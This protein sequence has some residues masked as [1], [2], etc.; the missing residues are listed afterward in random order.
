MIIVSSDAVIHNEEESNE[1]TRF[2]I[3]AGK[4]FEASAEC[5]KYS[6]NTGSSTLPISPADYDLIGI[7]KRICELNKQFM[8]EHDLTDDEIK[9]LVKLKEDAV[10]AYYE[11]MFD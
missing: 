6:V 9:E 2:N 7:R 11:R 1:S 8:E 10:S 4:I 5:N 3:I